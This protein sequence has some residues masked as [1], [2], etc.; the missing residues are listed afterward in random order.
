MV[1]SSF[2]V[3]LLQRQRCVFSCNRV[4]VW[5]FGFRNN[6]L[7]FEM[8]EQF[9]ARCG[10]HLARFCNAC[11]FRRNLCVSLA[12]CLD[13]SVLHSADSTSTI[14]GLRTCTDLVSPSFQS[15]FYPASRFRVF[16]VGYIA[17]GKNC[18]S[19]LGHCHQRSSC[20]VQ[21]QSISRTVTF[22]A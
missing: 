20:I 3:T 10:I 5:L 21:S 17:S 19:T 18:N 15:Q 22:S 6:S 8:P 11:L 14:N 1:V 16:L 12:S 9:S 13:I 2:H 4:V 7:D